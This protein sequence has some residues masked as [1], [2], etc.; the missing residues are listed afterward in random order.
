MSQRLYVRVTLAADGKTPQ[1]E[2]I[3]DQE[4]IA[5]LSFVDLLEFMMQAT[6]SLRW[7]GDVKR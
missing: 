1:R 2:L 3:L 4:K 7:D 5:E 6:S